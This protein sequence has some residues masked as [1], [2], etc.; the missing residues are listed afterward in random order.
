M[1]LLVSAC[2]LGVA[3][4]YDGR[5]AFNSE[6]FEIIKNHEIIPVCPEQ[7]GGLKTPRSPN[8]ISDGRVVEKNGTDNTA[9][10]KR[11][12]EEALKIAKLLDCKVAI[13]KERS[14]SCG[15]DIIY[16]GSFSGTRIPGEGVTTA[17]LRKNGI[18]VISEEHPEEIKKLLQ[19]N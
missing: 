11:G 3:S 14:P 2:L 16:D 15:S 6:L 7:L 12:A 4:R 17:L 19:N 1:K 9:E 18:R 13:L 5:T 10:Y 8:E